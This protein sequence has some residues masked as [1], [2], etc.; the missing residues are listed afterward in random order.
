[1]LK[2]KDYEKVKITSIKYKGGVVHFKY[3]NEHYILNNGGTDMTSVSTLYKGR[4][5]YKCEHISSC[6]GYISFLIEYK[7]NKKVL[8]YIDKENFVNRLAKAGLVEK[9]EEVFK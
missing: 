7:N 8:K 5:K 4:S 6:W 9:V 2:I 1:M 3:E